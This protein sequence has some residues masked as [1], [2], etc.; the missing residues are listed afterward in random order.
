MSWS[1]NPSSMAGELLIDFESDCILPLT[2]PCI[3]P[4]TANSINFLEFVFLPSPPSH[5]F[6]FHVCL[7]RIGQEGL[8]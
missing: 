3:E 5:L 2:V 7:F 4:V 8:S 6:Q 1:P